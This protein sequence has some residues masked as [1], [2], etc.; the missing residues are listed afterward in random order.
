MIKRSIL[1]F[2]IKRK[3]AAVGSVPLVK[4]RRILT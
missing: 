4:S 2:K 3:M 1:T